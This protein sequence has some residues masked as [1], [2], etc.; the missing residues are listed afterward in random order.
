MVVCHERRTGLVING[1]N[2]NAGAAIVMDNIVEYPALKPRNGNC[3]NT[4]MGDVIVSLSLSPLAPLLLPKY[5][6]VGAC[7][8]NAE[9]VER[10]SFSER[11]SRQTRVTFATVEDGVL[12]AKQYPF[13]ILLGIP[14]TPKLDPGLLTDLFFPN[15]SS[16]KNR[17]AGGGPIDCLLNRRE[18]SGDTEF[19]TMQRGK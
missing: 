12:S 18:I 13:G 10:A 19:A 17:V 6:I 3:G 14:G 5:I 9:T 2:R 4:E 16:N 7:P 8:R 1:T 11:D 15:A